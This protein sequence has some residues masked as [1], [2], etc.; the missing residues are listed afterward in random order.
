MNIVVAGG[1]GFV[2]GALVQHLVREGHR[3]V[4]LTRRPATAEA[5]KSIQLCAW[6]GKNQGAWS[7]ALHDADAVINLAGESIATRWSEIQ[8]AKIIQSRLDATQAIVTAIRAAGKRPKVLMNASAIGYYGHV[9][10]GK[11]TEN[12]PKGT[13]FLADTC[14]AWEQAAGEAKSLGVRVVLLRI[15]VVLEKGGG[16]LAKMLPPFQFFMGGPLGKGSQWFS[17]IHRD[18]LIG[19]ILFALRHENL[20]G[21]VNATAPNPATMKDFC[22]TLGR[23]MHRPSF[24]PVP[25]LVLKLLLGEMAQEMLLSGQRVVPSKLQEGGYAFQHPLLEEALHA[26]LHRK[27][28]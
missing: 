10:D 3:V 24:A 23:V 4:L 5:T 6:D 14:E 1:T 17:W 25:E 8:K 13:G 20:S 26:I 19:A 21:P 11:V 27:S 7:R 22:H 2:G 9:P 28:P 16:A 12:H 15:G 18:D